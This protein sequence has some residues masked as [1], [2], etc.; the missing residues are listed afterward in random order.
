M[1]SRTIR[2]VSG[3]LI[4]AAAALLL[5]ALPVDSSQA[6]PDQSTVPGKTFAAYR[7]GWYPINFV[8]HFDGALPGHWSVA[9]TGDGGS[10]GTEH[11]MFVMYSKPFKESGSH[12]SVSATL[13]GHAHKHGRWEIRFRGRQFEN[14]HTPY[15]LNAKLV[16]AGDRDQHCGGE[17]I[18]L[19]S[20]RANTSQAHFYDRTLG[21]GSFTAVKRRMNLSND[22][23]HTWA[24]EVTPRRI[25]WFVDGYVQRTETRPAALSGVPLTLRLELTAVPGQTMNTSR[26]QVDTVRYFPLKSANKKSVKAPRTVLRKYAAAC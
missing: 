8:D 12:G 20:Y 22:Y 19:A 5:V 7:Y 14:G 16:P 11:G 3:R 2:R 21:G 17:D 4:V 15:T 13:T 1:S 23:W 25:S 24:V 9:G 18:S 26:L 6:Q 10:V